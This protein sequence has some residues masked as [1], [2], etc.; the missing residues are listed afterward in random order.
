MQV[1][2]GAVQCARGA[3][4]DDRVECGVPAALRPVGAPRPLRRSDAR[5]GVRESPETSHTRVRP[6]TR[7]EYKTLVNLILFYYL[8]CK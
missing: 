8:C 6:Q 1:C 3:A 2:G 7:R 4:D 5:S